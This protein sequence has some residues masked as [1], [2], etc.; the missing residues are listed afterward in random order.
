MKI[1]K[2]KLPV[3]FLAWVV[4]LAPLRLLGQ[5]SCLPPQCEVIASQWIGRPIASPG[6]ITLDGESSALLVDQSQLTSVGEGR[7][8]GLTQATGNYAVMASRLNLP[9]RVA[10]DAQR[11]MVITNSSANQVIRFDG[12]GTPT[13]IAD[14]RFASAPFGLLIE[15]DGSVLWANFDNNG[16]APNS[17]WRL[18]SGSSTPVK[19]AGTGAW[20]NSGDNAPA[21][22]ATLANPWDLA[23]DKYGNLYVSQY[24]SNTLRRIDASSGNIVT[25]AGDGYAGFAGDGGPA[26]LSRLNKPSWLWMEHGQ[27]L[28]FFDQ[29]NARVRVISN[30]A[31]LGPSASI[32]TELQAYGISGFAVDQSYWYLSWASRQEVWRQLREGV[33]PRPTVTF[34]ATPTL[35]SPAPTSTPSRTST[36]SL[37][38]PTVS[39]L[40]ADLQSAATSIDSA[41]MRAGCR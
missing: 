26:R 30:V 23:R 20:G 16:S 31:D 41:K 25:I 34:V 35:T 29:G 27:D 40:C 2:V 11:R 7:I 21:T 32:S 8:F 37:F 39:F 36:S 10:Y 14:S 4:T 22:A 19:I 3:L 33:T 13:V 15:P 24:G 12:G 17:I 38:T 6:S 1:I 9:R 18:R 28:H 5:A